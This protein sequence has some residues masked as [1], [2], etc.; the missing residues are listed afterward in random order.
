MRVESVFSHS[1]IVSPAKIQHTNTKVHKNRFRDN[2]TG[3][4]LMGEEY[5]GKTKMGKP[6]Q[7]DCPEFQPSLVHSNPVS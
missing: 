2:R 3:E 6:R 5:A 1:L 4:K 7:K